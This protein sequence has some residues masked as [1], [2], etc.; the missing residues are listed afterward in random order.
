MLFK[1]CF[2]DRVTLHGVIVNLTKYC[3]AEVTG[4]S[5][6]GIKFNKETRISNAAFKKFPKTK[7]E[8]KNLEKIGDFYELNQIKVTWR[9]VLSCI[10]KAIKPSLAHVKRK[11]S[12][13]ETHPKRIKVEEG[14]RVHKKVLK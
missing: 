2:E 11:G 1:K 13:S 4:L 7:V 5:K 14:A 8:E 6:E 10:H 9:D 3:I 12:R